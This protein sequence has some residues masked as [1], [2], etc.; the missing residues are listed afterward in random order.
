MKPEL[1]YHLGHLFYAIAKADKNLAFKEY[2]QL[3]H[4]LEKHWSFI[5]ENGIQQIKTQFNAL[6][7]TNASA[8]ESFNTFVLFLHQNPKAFDKDLKSLILKT[9]NEIA[10]AFANI[11]KS[12]LN[13][14][15]TLNLEFKKL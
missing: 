5:G 13:F 12:E 15:A 9:A 6:Q 1:L 14:M 4:S 3:S 8:T 11:N 2:V 7:Q 10:Y